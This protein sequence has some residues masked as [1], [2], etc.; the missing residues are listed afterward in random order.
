MTYFG[1]A[2]KAVKVGRPSI[3]NINTRVVVERNGKFQFFNYADGH[4]V[5]CPHM[6]AM[7]CDPP[8]LEMEQMVELEADYS[9]AQRAAGAIF[10]AALYHKR[11]IKSAATRKANKAIAAAKIAA[12]IEKERIDRENY[13]ER[14]MIKILAI[15]ERNRQEK[16]ARIWAE[17]E[18]KAE[19]ERLRQA[20]IEARAKNKVKLNSYQRRFAH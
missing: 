14:W 19:M 4:W 13:V 17:K 16:H 11:S 2:R 7:L 8:V 20:K 9:S 15:E 12:E 3:G 18:R 6:N 5:D 1:N 10:L